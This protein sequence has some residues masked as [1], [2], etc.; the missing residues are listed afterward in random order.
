MDTEVL[1]REDV[2]PLGRRGE[3]VRV[4]KGYARNYLFPRR[5]ALRPTPGNRR[6]FELEKAALA[7]RDRL[8]QR[9]AHEVAAALEKTSVTIEAN[10]NPEG[11]LYGSVDAR[12]VADAFRKAG[13]AVAP[14]MIRLDEPIKKVGVYSVTIRPHGD[15]A[16]VGKVWVVSSAKDEGDAAA[17]GSQA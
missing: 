16:A 1:L 4:S 7:R 3:V 5:L 11:A 13:V 10:A 8:R 15:V 9:K 14:D 17:P 6:L 12:A 2:L